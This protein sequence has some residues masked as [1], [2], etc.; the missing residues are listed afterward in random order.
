MT[1]VGL[2]GLC[3]E[4][5]LIGRRQFVSEKAN[6]TYLSDFARAFAYEMR[7]SHT[8]IQNNVIYATVSGVISIEDSPEIVHEKTYGR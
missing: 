2:F 5:V 8:T 1:C 7:L 4:F 6:V 3:I